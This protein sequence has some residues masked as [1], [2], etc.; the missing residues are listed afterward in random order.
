MDFIVDFVYS[1]V[2]TF[3]LAYFI[4]MILGRKRKISII[5]LSI[6]FIYQIISV[7]QAFLIG[8]PIDSV[9]LLFLYSPTPTI[10]AFFLFMTFTGGFS[11]AHVKRKKLKN[12]SN[13]IQT[14]RLTEIASILVVIF[15]VILA[16]ISIFLLEEPN[17]L[18]LIVCIISFI[19][20]IYMLITVKKIKMEK[21]ILFVGINKEKIYF[22]DIPK[23]ALKVEV[24]D[25]YKNEMYIVDA[26]GEATLYQE[27]KKY[28]KHY[29]YWIGTG[30]KID[31]KD[32]EVVELRSLVYKDYLDHF[33]KY[34]YKKVVFIENRNGTAEFV[35]EKLVK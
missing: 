26:I 22:Y 7:I 35:K 23:N 20:G 13:H 24:K 1:S 32:E 30:D 2:S 33:E 6:M 11:F 21:V 34:H 14:K 12:L 3:I 19:L 8:F 31:M 4:Y 10:F 29:L 17:Y 27:D 16:P 28:E 5:I 25:F 9:I 15:A 18:V